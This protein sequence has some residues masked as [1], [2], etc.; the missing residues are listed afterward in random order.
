MLPYIFI[1]GSRE[2]R[3]V[4]P[5]QQISRFFISNIDLCPYI[6]HAHHGLDGTRLRAL[7]FII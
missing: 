7:L 6:Y 5:M 2:H 1:F 3:T 4:Q